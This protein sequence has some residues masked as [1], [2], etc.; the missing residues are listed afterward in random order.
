M[1]IEYGSKKKQERLEQ[2]I[3]N[4]RAAFEAQTEIIIEMRDH[5]MP[6]PV[7]FMYNRQK[8]PAVRQVGA[9]GG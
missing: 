4:L 6:Q 1:G 5:L 3:K 2:E 7:N 8:S 9:I